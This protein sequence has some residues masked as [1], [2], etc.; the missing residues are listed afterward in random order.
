[1]PFLV[2]YLF[3]TLPFTYLMFPEDLMLCDSAHLIF[4][5]FSFSINISFSLCIT[6]GLLLQFLLVSGQF[7]VGGI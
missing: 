4:S 7:K 6:S 5:E 2:V 1:M 3:E